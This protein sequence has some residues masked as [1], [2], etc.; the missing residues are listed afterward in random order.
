[1]MQG[2]AIFAKVDTQANP[3]T[4]QQFQIRSIPSL[5]CFKGGKE[6]ARQAGAMPQQALTQWVH[7][8]I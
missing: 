2:R 4:S 3:G 8:V 1:N 7:Q 5:L 6:S